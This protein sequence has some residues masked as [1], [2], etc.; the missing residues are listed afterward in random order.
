MSRDNDFEPTKEEMSRAVAEVKR[1]FS[2]TKV[3]AR[4][5]KGAKYTLMLTSSTKLPPPPENSES[6]SKKGKKKRDK[7][8]GQQ[9]VDEVP[10]NIVQAH[11][12]RGTSDQSIS[13]GIK[14]VEAN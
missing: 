14:K 12:T 3:A 2:K 8:A 10:T 5:A 6:L 7:S 9:A 4:E 11:L 13:D 1:E